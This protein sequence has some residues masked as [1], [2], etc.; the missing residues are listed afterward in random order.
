MKGNRATYRTIEYLA[1]EM[2]MDLGEGAHRKEQY[3][4]WLIK[5][6]EKWK[7]D[8]AREIKTVEL[9]M[10]PWKSVVLPSDCIRWGKLGIQ[11][12]DVLKVFVNRNDIATI[13]QIN[14]N[15]IKQPNADPVSITSLQLDPSNIT[16]PFFNYTSSGEN[17]GKLFGFAVKDNGFGYF[18]VNKN[19]DT[20]EIQFR[21][22]VAS[23]SKIVLEYLA[24][25]WNPTSQTLIHPLAS[26]LIVLGAHYRRL[27]F[28]RTR[29]KN[30][31]FDDVRTAKQD[32]NEEY[33]RVIDRMWDYTIEDILEVTNKS[34]TLTA[35]PVQ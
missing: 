8:M 9:T 25:S 33:D 26:E 24:D 23:T 5:E 1:D 10:T 27:K 11:D 4:H 7:S 34:Y 30:I 3:L 22:K 29:N 6:A 19:E 15:N 12:G 18:T 31:S 16:Y 14:S 32:R 35:N 17:P 28:D 20:D 13:H 21:T 2:C